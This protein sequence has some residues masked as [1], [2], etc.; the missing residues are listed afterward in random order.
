MVLATATLLF[1]REEAARPPT[2]IGALLLV[3]L[4]T[5]SWQQYRE[6]LPARESTA[7]ARL[8]DS[9]RSITGMDS[10]FV[11][12]SGAGFVF[13]QRCE[14]LVVPD[15]VNSL[16]EAGDAARA[17]AR[18]FGLALDSLTIAVAPGEAPPDWSELRE[19]DPAERDGWRFFET[20]LQH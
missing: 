11:R 12:P 4:L 20:R 9:L 5:L 16:S 3:A 6:E 14:R 18:R 19:L 2:A 17:Y 13:L 1:P 15:A 8:A 7:Q 10:V